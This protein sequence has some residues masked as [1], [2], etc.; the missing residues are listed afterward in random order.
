MLTSS[1]Q[2]IYSKFIHS[3]AKKYWY[4]ITNSTAKLY[5]FWVDDAIKWASCYIQYIYVYVFKANRL[6]IV[7]YHQ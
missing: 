2:G 4:Y 5:H 3:I 7:A 1:F 6:R